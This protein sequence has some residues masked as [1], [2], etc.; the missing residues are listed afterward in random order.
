M[1]PRLRHLPAAREEAVAT[2]RERHTGDFEL[3]PAEGANLLA[4]VQVPQAQGRIQTAGN[5]PMTVRR[6][7]H[8]GNRSRVPLETAQRFTR[9][10]IPKTEHLATGRGYL[11][12]V[13]DSRSA[14]SRQR[15][16]AV[17]RKRHAPD[18]RGGVLE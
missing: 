4:T 13:G 3:G 12:V 14:P 15:P 5:G 17:R 10:R 6:K 11:T 7:G 2:G 8:T 18:R 1:R 16:A 9:G